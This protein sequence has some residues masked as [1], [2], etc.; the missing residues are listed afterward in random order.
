ML[1][2]LIFNASH[3]KNWEKLTWTSYYSDHIADIFEC[4][5]A[6]HWLF[7]KF[8]TVLLVSRIA[9]DYFM[10]ISCGNETRQKWHCIDQSVKG[11][12]CGGMVKMKVKIF[13]LWR[14]LQMFNKLIQRRGAWCQVYHHFSSIF[15]ILEARF[16]SVT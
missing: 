4:F 12:N 6:A 2:H 1:F 14:T 7:Y 3:Y 9:T 13:L 15:N 11:K 5:S 10:S 8:Y 16:P